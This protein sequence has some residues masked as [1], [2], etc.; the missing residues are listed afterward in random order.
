MNSFL[1]CCSSDKQPISL[2]Q[3]DQKDNQCCW[4]GGQQ[5]RE[6]LFSFK[7]QSLP[8]GDYAKTVLKIVFSNYYIS[9]SPSPINS[10]Y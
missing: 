4:S 3:R 1:R 5:R 2:Y 7:Q 6:I 9:F 10:Y 8:S